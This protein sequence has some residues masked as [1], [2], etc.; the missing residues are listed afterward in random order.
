MWNCKWRHVNSHE[1]IQWSRNMVSSSACCRHHVMM[2]WTEL[3]FHDKLILSRGGSNS[4]FF[5][6]IWFDSVCWPQ[7]SGLSVRL[8]LSKAWNMGSDKE[9]YRYGR[10]DWLL[11]MYH[12][13][14]LQVYNDQSIAKDFLIPTHPQASK[15]E[16]LIENAQ[17]FVS[18]SETIIQII[19]NGPSR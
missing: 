9:M 5:L 1:S 4:F 17:D 3:E 14:W 10:H 16:S 2:S 7:I 12:T 8:W 18:K 13:I 11:L 6:S 19:N 15:P